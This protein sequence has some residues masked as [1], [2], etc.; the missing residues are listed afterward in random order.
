MKTTYEIYLAKKYIS[1][2]E[3]LQLI[4]TISDYQGIL[5]KWKLIISIQ[6][7]LYSLF[8]KNGI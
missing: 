3:W 1:K 7:K 4:K 8:Y 6:K 2:E 5:K